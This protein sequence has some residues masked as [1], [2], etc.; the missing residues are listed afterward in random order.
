MIPQFNN[1]RI[2][3]IGEVLWDNLPGRSLPGGALLNISHHLHKKNIP[4]TLVSKV[5]ADSKG[6]ALLGRMKEIGLNTNEIYFDDKLPTS[7]T[8]IIIDRLENI[9]YMIGG[10]VAWDNLKIN[11]KIIDQ[12]GTAGA[13]VYGSLASRNRVT[14]E[15]IN[16]L[17]NFDIVKIMNVNLRPPFDDKEIVEA[18]LMKAD[19]VRLN[20]NELDQICCW[21][22]K[23]F[24][25][26]RDQLQWF[27]EYYKCKIICVNNRKNGG[28]V[29]SDNKLYSHPGYKV[30]TVDNVGIGAAFLAG[31]IS[32]LILEKTIEQSLDTACVTAALTATSAGAIYDYNR[33]N[34]YQIN[35]NLN[36]VKVITY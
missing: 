22:N 6:I 19:I 14:R 12:A 15:T 8:K 35:S 36:K 13:I 5:G 3:C 23:V 27:M 18:L 25:N 21:H 29:Y 24:I 34:I 26:K 16:I 30:E 2:L 4:V 20:N 17:L 1:N 31:F 7:E 28:V 11:M 32:S 9:K 33:K 10:P